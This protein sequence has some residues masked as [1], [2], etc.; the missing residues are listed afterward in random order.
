M[1]LIEGD[2]RLSR[3]LTEADL[4]APGAGDWYIL[5]AG[6][7]VH[8]VEGLFLRPSGRAPDLRLVSSGAYRLL[9]DLAKSDL[10]P[11]KQAWSS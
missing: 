11:G 4:A 5:V 10:D 8:A 9:W 2:R 1:H 3:S 7:E 6:T